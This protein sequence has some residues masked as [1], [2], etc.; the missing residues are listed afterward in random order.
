M[1]PPK[2]LSPVIVA[3]IVIVLVSIAIAAV[4]IAQKPNENTAVTETT[5]QDAI[6]ETE[7]QTE[8][9]AATSSTEADTY[10][11]GTYTEKGRYVSP[12]GAESIDVTVT[13]ANDIITSAI[14]KGNAS[15]GE[16]KD[17]QADFIGGFK[18]SVVGKDVDSVSL[19][20]VAGSSLTS[21]GFNT[22]LNLIK[23][24]AKA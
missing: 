15:R 14:V 23:A 3:L 22:A 11:D 10:K 20:R 13:I 5:Q 12:G 19:S 7:A 17:H 4:V 2:K 8:T 1:E 9:P 21:N 18:S 16:S 6:T 24:D